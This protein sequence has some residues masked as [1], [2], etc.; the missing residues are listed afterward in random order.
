MEIQSNQPKAIMNLES[1]AQG[2]WEVAIPQDL[3]PGLHKIIVETEDGQQQDL[4]LFN[5]PSSSQVINKLTVVKNYDFFLYPAAIL[6]L[7]VLILALNN[8]RLM[9]KTKLNKKKLEEKQKKV[10]LIIVLISLLA[11]GIFAK[12]AYQT[13]LMHRDNAINNLNF[14]NTQDEQVTK[15]PAKLID[16]RGLVVDPVTNLALIGADLSAG[17][18]NIRI[19]DGGAYVFSQIPEDEG[20]VITHP[21]FKK[22]VNKKI[23]LDEQGAMDIYLSPDMIN[24]LISVV[25]FEASGQ[26]DRIYQQLPEKLINNLKEEDFIKGFIQNFDRSDLSNQQITVKNINKRE[27][28][29]LDKYS[30]LLPKAIQVDL[31]R[32]QEMITYFLTIEDGIWKA[33]K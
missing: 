26:I 15:I 17:D 4:A 18:V 25:D 28:V 22:A 32:S 10:T 8:L 24:A 13:S 5:A 11:M 2:N 29:V 27:E 20:I 30:L 1:D 21:Q 31:Q 7:L 23:S 14:N 12:L 6:T 3:P 19:Q 9:V 33:I 16:V